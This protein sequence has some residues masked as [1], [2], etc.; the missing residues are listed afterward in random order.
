M[1]DKFL[2]KVYGIKT[3]QDA[4]EVYDEWSATYDDEVAEN[5]YAT[6]ARCAAVLAEHLNPPTQPILDFGCGTGLSGTALAAL[7]FTTIDGIDLS[8]GMLETAKKRNVYRNLMHVPADAPIPVAPG[9]YA[10]IAAVGVITTGAAPAALLDSL[11]ALLVPGGFIVFSF[12]DHALED[13]TY[14]AR[15]KTNLDAGVARQVSR[16]YGDH[17]PGIDIK[18]AVY[19][20]EKI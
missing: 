15:V 12:N 7:G 1:A 9:D 19:L 5:G 2:D 8:A 14:E 6:P 3:A 16:T 17:L 11:L 13:P 20:L 4:Q 10:A 18:S